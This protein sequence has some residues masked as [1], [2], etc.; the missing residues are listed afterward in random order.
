MHKNNPYKLPPL[1]MRVWRQ[2]GL[3][4]P[5]DPLGGSRLLGD[6][7]DV[8]GIYDFSVSREADA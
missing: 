3:R 7:P 8:A 2:E 4:Q 1:K 5:S 6:A